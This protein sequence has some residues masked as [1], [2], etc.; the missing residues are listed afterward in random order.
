MTRG[1]MLRCLG[2]DH[3]NTPFPILI[4]QLSDDVLDGKKCTHLLDCV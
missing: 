2:T 3:Y 4:F 1:D